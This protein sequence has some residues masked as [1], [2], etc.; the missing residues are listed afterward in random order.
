[1]MTYNKQ[2]YEKL[3]LENGFE[4]SQDMF[5]FTGN[6]SMLDSLDPKLQ[7]V[8]DEAKRRFKVTTRPIDKKNFRR[9]TGG[10]CFWLA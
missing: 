4:K 2:Y 3:I 1:M 7:F 6:V 8:V 9:K 10:M 5:A